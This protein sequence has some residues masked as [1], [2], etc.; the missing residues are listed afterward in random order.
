[1]TSSMQS[2]DVDQV[3]SWREACWHARDS[4]PATAP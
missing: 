3:Q 2:I 1:M 4:A